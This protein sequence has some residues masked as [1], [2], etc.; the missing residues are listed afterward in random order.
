MCDVYP[1][2]ALLIASI[3]TKIIKYFISVYVVLALSLVSTSIGS[4]LQIFAK[5]IKCFVSGS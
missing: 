3:F 1:D 2:L 4:L 5:I